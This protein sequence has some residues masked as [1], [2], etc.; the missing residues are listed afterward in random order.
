MR[1]DG[2]YTQRMV[3][4]YLLGAKYIVNLGR[5][6]GVWSVDSLPLKFIGQMVFK[7]L[8]EASQLDKETRAFQIEGAVCVKQRKQ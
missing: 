6:G 1:L 4:V 5:P 7:D 8:I 2:I 3:V